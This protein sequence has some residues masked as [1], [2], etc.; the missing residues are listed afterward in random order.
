MIRFVTVGIALAILFPDFSGG[1]FLFAQDSRL[2]STTLQQPTIKP[3]IYTIQDDA[4]RRLMR[5][6]VTDSMKAIETQKPAG[7]GDSGSPEEQTEQGSISGGEIQGKKTMPTLHNISIRRVTSGVRTLDP[8]NKPENIRRYKDWQQLNESYAVSVA[9]LTNIVPIFK[10]SPLR[11]DPVVQAFQSVVRFALFDPTRWKATALPEPMRFFFSSPGIDGIAPEEI[12]FDS[13]NGEARVLLLTEASPLPPMQ[14]EMYTYA[15]P[16]GV[17]IGVAIE[18]VLLFASRSR[19]LQGW[20]LESV[21]ITV[22]LRGADSTERVSINF[23]ADKGSLSPAT[24]QLRGGDFATVRLRSRGTGEATVEVSSPRYSTQSMSMMYVFPWMFFISALLGGLLGSLV[25]WL[26]RRNEESTTQAAKS[27]AGWSLFGL[28]A[29]VLYLTLGVN[30]IGI[31]LD[32]VDYF[33]EIL[34]FGIA[35]L[36]PIAR[37]MLQKQEK[38][39]PQG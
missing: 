35:A 4:L 7:T 12:A 21:P 32:D 28:I 16:E 37:G 23:T 17:P 30:L 25:I 33:N 31:E 34:V 18:P 24:L 38:A 9:G 11:Y 27:I 20:G 1:Y 22:L 10:V 14:F 19:I 3:R 29:A 13:T 6:R 5:D 8:G 39:A 15:Q 26:L 36:A 2:R